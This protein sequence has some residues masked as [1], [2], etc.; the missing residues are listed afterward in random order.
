MP[1]ELNHIAFSRLLHVLLDT[2]ADLIASRRAADRMA[3]INQARR[4]S[5]DDL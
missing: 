3:T 5:L 1:S 4:V 2:I